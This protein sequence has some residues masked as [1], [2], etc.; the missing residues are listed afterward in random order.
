MPTNAEI[1]QTW[2]VSARTSRRVL[3][4]L[5]DEGWAEPGGT[6]GYT[7]TGGPAPRI[8][9]GGPPPFPYQASHA[10][11]DQAQHTQPGPAPDQPADP[12]ASP[13]A[14]AAPD[15]EPDP[16][17][18]PRPAHTIAIG[19]DI[20]AELSAVRILSVAYEPAPADVA[21]AL[22][23]DGPGLPVLV[24]RRLITDPTGRLPLEL[25]TSYIP[26]VAEHGTLTHPDPLPGTW[27]ENLTDYTPREPATAA[28]RISTR[29][30]TPWDAALQ[31]PPGTYA[32]TRAT[33]TADAHGIPIDHTVSVWP[34]ATTIQ[35]DIPLT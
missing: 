13:A 33:T 11:P 27:M 22:H 32:L 21:A 30:A 7:S 25:R 23:M 4:L 31:L 15:Q 8:A 5:T 34:E 9:G 12:A 17:S 3:A 6:R 1:Q 20:P 26:G 18:L 2:K 16:L 14:S 28:V 29:P 24:R 19:S 35:T 10:P